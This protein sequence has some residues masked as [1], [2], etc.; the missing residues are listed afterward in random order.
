[1]NTSLA[2]PKQPWKPA[3]ATD[4]IRG[5]AINSRL[6]LH[7]SQHAKDQMM[8]REI[9]TSDVLHVLK[10]GFVY[11]RPEDA[12]KANCFKY[13]IESTSPVGPKVVKLVVIPWIS[14]PEIKIVTVM[15]RD[16][17]N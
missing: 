2:S 4:Q 8:E 9:Y 10:H 15:W 5:L 16:E 12:T 11:D 6:A 3:D 17:K 1:M 13:K 7:L 14:P